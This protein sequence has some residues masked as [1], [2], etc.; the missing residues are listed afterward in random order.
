MP[1][2]KDTDLIT[3]EMRTA[4][5]EAL[6]EYRVAQKTER[7]EICRRMDKGVYDDKPLLKATLK[8]VRSN[9]I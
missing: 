4:L 7:M 8:N 9:I 2:Q 5:Q 1:A 3:E 6:E